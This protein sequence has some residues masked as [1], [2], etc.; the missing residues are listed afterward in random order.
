MDR[1]EWPGCWMC[2]HVE[3]AH[4]WNEIGGGDSGAK[5][6]IIGCHCPAYRI[7]KLRDVDLTG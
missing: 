1:L 4:D 6:L 5:C 3:P 7:E 2:G